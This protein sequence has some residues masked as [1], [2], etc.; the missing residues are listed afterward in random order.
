MLGPVQ[1]N[2]Y[3][4][5]GHLSWPTWCSTTFQILQGWAAVGNHNQFCFALSDHFHCLLLPQHVLCTFHN[6]LES[7][8]DWLLRL[9]IFSVAT[10]FLPQVWDGSQPRA[11]TKQPVSLARHH[12]FIVYLPTLV[13][14]YH[15]SHKIT[16]VCGEEFLSWPQLSWH[17]LL[18]FLIHPH[19]SEFLCCFILFLLPCLLLFLIFSTSSCILVVFPPHFESLLISCLLGLFGKI[20]YV[21][22][23]TYCEQIVW[24]FVCLF[25]LFYFIF[26]VLWLPKE[27]PRVGLH[28]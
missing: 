6:K 17:L 22:P 13:L 7:R 18:S 24:F 11:A 8:V 9:F 5:H 15:H 23:D 20:T 4:G 25:I 3:C 28:H 16:L 21:W 12:F 1:Y 2:C 26:P 27:G 19:N 14:E 10:I